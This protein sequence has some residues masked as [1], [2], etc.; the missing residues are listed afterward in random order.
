MGF[1]GYKADYPLEKIIVEDCPVD[2][3][4]NTKYDTRF[5]KTDLEVSEW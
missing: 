3:I 5:V 4:F 1:P 2:S